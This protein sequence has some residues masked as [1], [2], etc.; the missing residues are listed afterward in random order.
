MNLI[1]SQI[2][3]QGASILAN[4][5]LTMMKALLVLAFLGMMLMSLE[6]SKIKTTEGV[7]PPVFLIVTASWSNDIDVDVD[8]HIRCPNGHNLN[9]AMKEACFANLERDARGSVSDF[10]QFSS[11]KV[12]R[13]TNKE[14]VSFRTPVQGEWIVNVNWYAMGYANPVDVKIEITA[15]EPNVRVLY[16]KTVQLNYPKHE[17]HVVRF[18]VHDDKRVDSF[19]DSRTIKLIGQNINNLQGNTP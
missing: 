12:T 16:E 6:I 3:S 18:K 8:L 4:F 19:D 7:K 1:K 9:Y 13:I 5:S 2:Q 15:I 10:I 14:I 17:Q 11:Q